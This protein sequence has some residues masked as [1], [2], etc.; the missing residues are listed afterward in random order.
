MK[1]GTVGTSWITESFIEAAKESGKMELTAVYSRSIE[2]ARKISGKYDASQV[3]DDLEGMAANE[4]IDAV[5]LASPN[6]HHYEHAKLFLRHKKHVICEKPIFSNTA[7]LED[8]YQV[9][10][11]NGVFLFE[12]MRNIHSPNAKLLKEQVDKAG[13]L[14]S[15]VFQYIQYSSRYDR[16]L[17]GERP[18]I[19][20]TDFSGG[21]L[22][23]LGVYPISLAVYVFGEPEKVSY[24]PVM[25]ESGVDGSGTLVMEYDGF[26]CT[27]LCSKIAH[28]FTPSEIHGEQVSLVL[29]HVAPINK[30][31]LVDRKTKK[32]EK[33]GEPL[34]ENDMIYEIETFA[35]IIEENDLEAYHELT[36]YSRAVLRI[37][38]TA[39]KQ[40]NIVF[41]TEK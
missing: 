17:E 23:D 12:A 7:E 3:Y 16:F 30:I 1:F 9:A 35:K 8:A 34:N 36:D 28:S 15:A 4:E 21:T 14:R 6:S 31:S 29:D 26:I 13:K 37:T 22:V 19:F 20:S 41:G 25:L 11:E 18:N 5:Y 10:E 2:N 24:H 27:I 38:E 32:S 33:L 39:R 40:N